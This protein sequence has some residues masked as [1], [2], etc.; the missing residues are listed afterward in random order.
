MKVPFF[1]SLH[2]TLYSQTFN[3]SDAFGCGVVA[4]L[5]LICIS[6]ITNGFH[7]I[8]ICFLAI[9]ISS[10]KT[11]LF[12]SI[13]CFLNWVVFLLLNSKSFFFLINA[14]YTS[15]TID[16]I[17][18]ISSHYLDFLFLFLNLMMSCEVQIIFK[19]FYEVHFS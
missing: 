1:Y 12:V 9:C 7:H 15:L 4:H 3:F 5:V 13:D 18:K 14:G 10:L 6:L 17:C 16:R 2:N 8:F 11:C 19:D